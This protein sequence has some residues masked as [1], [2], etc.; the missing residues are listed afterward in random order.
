MEKKSLLDKIKEQIEW[1]ISTTD[2]DLVIARC[3]IILSMLE[4]GE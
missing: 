4:E 1:I 3:N 2:D